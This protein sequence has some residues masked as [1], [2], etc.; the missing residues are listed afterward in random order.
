MIEEHKLETAEYIN[1]I[2][3]VHKGV[4]MPEEIWDRVSFHIDTST[5][6]SCYEAFKLSPFYSILTPKLKNKLVKY[7]LYPLEKKFQ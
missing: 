1:D 3:K 2:N 5:R 6:Y 4:S 7:C